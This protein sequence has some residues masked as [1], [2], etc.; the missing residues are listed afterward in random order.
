MKNKHLLF[1]WEES[2]YYQTE[3]L[4][5]IAKIYEDFS[6]NFCINEFHSVSH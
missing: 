4:Q 5:K 3:Y 6:C 1:V 2:L